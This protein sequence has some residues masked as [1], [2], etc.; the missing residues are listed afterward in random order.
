TK[1]SAYWSTSVSDHGGIREPGECD[2]E[3]WLDSAWPS[4][5]S[6]RVDRHRAEP[7]GIRDHQVLDQQVT[8]SLPSAK[9]ERGV[10]VTVRDMQTLFDYGYWANRKLFPTVS[11]I[12]RA[13]V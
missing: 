8:G 6:L 12:G 5:A 11:E 3:I 4:R 2:V 13:H 9:T 7:A 10:Q 1:E